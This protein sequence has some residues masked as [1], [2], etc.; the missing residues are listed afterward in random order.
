[1]FNRT[2]LK[3]SALFREQAFINGSWVDG[4]GTFDVLDPASGA[5]IATNPTAGS[6]TVEAIEAADE[7]WAGW[8]ALTAKVTV[9]PVSL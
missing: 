3:D 4:S 9:C 8:K 7:A 1:M 2:E 5:K 6:K